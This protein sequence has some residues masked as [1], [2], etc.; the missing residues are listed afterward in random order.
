MPLASIEEAARFYLP[1]I[2]DAQPR[3]PYILAGYSLGGVTALEIARLLQ[4]SG[5]EVA[6]V[7]MLDTLTP[8]QH[9]PWRGKIRLWA[10]RALYHSARLRHLPLQQLPAYLAGRAKGF[11]RDITRNAAAGHSPTSIKTN[12]TRPRK[13][14]PL[15]A[16]A[17]SEYRPRFYSGSVVFIQ[18]EIIDQWV[19]YY[20]DVLWRPLTRK[21]SLYRVKGD[22]W[23]MLSRHSD[24]IADAFSRCLTA[25]PRME[26][27]AQMS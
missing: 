24:S 2:R 17:F 23:T 13:P 10:R 3:G 11:G 27:F 16:I 5:E 1:L 9:F 25:S 15:A 6:H 22:H 21:F 7:I 14:A 8:F 18:A 26:A 19:P 12:L 20:P 4:A